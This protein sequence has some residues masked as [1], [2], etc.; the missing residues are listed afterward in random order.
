MC[1]VAIIVPFLPLRIYGRDLYSIMGVGFSLTYVGVALVA[2]TLYGQPI[3]SNLFDPYA[4]FGLTLLL[5]AV[6]T[7]VLAT[8]RKMDRGKTLFSFP[9]DLQSLRRLSLVCI[10]IGLVGAIL[11]GSNKSMESGGSNAGAA[12]ILGKYLQDFFYLGLIAEVLY[13]ITKS[14]GRSFVTFRLGLWLF[15]ETLIAV[16]L[17]VREA[18]LSSLIGVVTA[19]FLFNML[20]VRHLLIGML[21]V[22]FFINFMTPV[23]IYLRIAKEGLS[24]TQFME[25]AVNTFAKAAT[26]QGFFQ[27]LSDTADAAAIQNTNAL[28]AYDYY[29]TPANVLGRLSWVALVDAV[30]NGT[31]TRA[32]I[33]MAALDETLA[34]TAP[35]FLGY[36]KSTQGMGDWLSWQ[37]GLSEPG[38]VYYAVFGLPMEGLASWGLI[39]MIAYPFIFMLPMLYICGTLSSF[40]LAL[41]VSIFLFT[42]VQHSM[43]ESTSETFVAF[44][45]RGDLFLFVVLFLLSKYLSSRSL[46]AGSKSHAAEAPN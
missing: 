39:G 6:L 1:V 20:R 24:L 45:T 21:A 41:P 44:L 9:T 31:R 46:G 40:R 13:A 35:G 34:A 8:A 32:P 12:L 27:M 38:R 10:G 37:T 16:A 26:D 29:H 42:A 28:V 2:K 19:A 22:V 3:D 25:L 30:Y 33:G 15:L 4:A 11:V 14:E 7:A 5:M 18:L 43:L 23:T 36:R 17:N